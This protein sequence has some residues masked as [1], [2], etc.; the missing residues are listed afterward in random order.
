MRPVLTWLLLATLAA[1]IV[2]LAMPDGSSQLVGTADR[3]EMLQGT[4]PRQP[5]A[6]SGDEA[7]HKTPLPAQLPAWVLEPAKRDAFALLPQRPPPEAPTRPLA[8]NMQVPEPVESPP[9]MPPLPYRFWG[10][11]S[12]PEGKELVYLIRKGQRVLAVQPGVLLDDGWRVEAV[13]HEAV[14][15][16]FGGSRLHAQVNIPPPA[17]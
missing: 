11:M 15:L 8:R 14:T 10:R 7:G 1:S 17:K 3:V 9:P 2:S 16:S 5:L 13:S 6:S 12:T 4:A